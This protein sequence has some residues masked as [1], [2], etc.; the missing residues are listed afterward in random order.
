MFLQ[1]ERGG[2][3]LNVA[4]DLA[5]T[6]SMC[7]KEGA[8]LSSKSPFPREGYLMIIKLTHDIEQALAEEA[9]KLGTTPEQL[10]LDSLR[11]RFV[12]REPPPSPAR[13]P[14][15]LADS[16]ADISACCIA[17][18]TS[19]VAHA[20]QKP[21]GKSSPRDCSHSASNDGHDTHGY[22]ALGGAV[23]CR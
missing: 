21:V 19:L 17:V 20:C 16:C 1:T 18:N 6:E 7:R 23:G 14:E 2:L 5:T 3:G 15:T 10:A 9:R 8:T 11:E 12:G 22:W 4:I 13:E